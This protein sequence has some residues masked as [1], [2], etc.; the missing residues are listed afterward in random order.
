LLA[1][2]CFRYENWVLARSPLPYCQLLSAVPAGIEPFGAHGHAVS[3]NGVTAFA[4][5]AVRE[6]VANATTVAAARPPATMRNTN[7]RMQCHPP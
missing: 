4:V 5:P 2:I 6:A 1:L 3:W 7:L